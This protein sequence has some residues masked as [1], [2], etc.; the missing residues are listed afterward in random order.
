MSFLSPSATLQLANVSSST[1]VYSTIPIMKILTWN[2]IRA[3]NNRFHSH[4]RQLLHTHKILVIIEPLGHHVESN[5]ELSLSNHFQVDS[6][7]VLGSSW[8]LWRHQHQNEWQFTTQMKAFTLGIA[9]LDKQVRLFQTKITLSQLKVFFQN[10]RLELQLYYDL[11]L[12]LLLFINLLKIFPRN[13]FLFLFVL[14][15][16]LLVI[17]Q[18]I[19]FFLI[20]TFI[21][22]DIGSLFLYT[23]QLVDIYLFFKLINY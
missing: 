17:G 2:V 20:L 5:S 8:L 12:S 7:N 10:K 19:S 13:I 22:R 11:I 16:I 6:T 14:T 9:S 18:L 21:F 1:K 4:N 3:R 15:V 23:F